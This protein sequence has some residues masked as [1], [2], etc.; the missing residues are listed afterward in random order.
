[1]H[2]DSS[3]YFVRVQP[4]LPL[5]WLGTF[6]AMEMAIADADTKTRQTTLRVQVIDQ[7]QLLS[8]LNEIHGMGLLL[9]SVES[10]PAAIA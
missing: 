10:Q 5:H 8:V 7:A 4:I 3:T 6:S 9:L 1:M 2:K